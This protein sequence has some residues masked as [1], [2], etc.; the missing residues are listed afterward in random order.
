MRLLIFTLLLS[1]FST[2]N[3]FAQDNHCLDFNGVNNIAARAD[4]SISGEFTISAWF[5]CDVASNSS[6]DERII[7]FGPDTRL[8][9]GIDE[10][11]NELWLFDQSQN[12]TLSF[13]EDLRDQN[14]HQFAFVKLGT[15]RLV[16]IDGSLAGS[17]FATSNTTYGDDFRIGAWVGGSSSTTFFNGKVDDVRIWSVAKSADEI[18]EGL[19]CPLTG[20]EDDLLAY[21]NFD[22]GNPG[23]LNAL[24][25]ILLD[26]SGNARHCNLSSNFTLVGN[27]SNWVAAENDQLF[28]LDASINQNGNELVANASGLNYQW[29]DCDD[30]FSDIAGATTEVFAPEASGNYA[31]VVFNTTCTEASDCFD[32]IL[33]NTN[34]ALQNADIRVYPNPSVDFVIVEK[35]GLE[36]LDI[37]VKDQI[38]NTLLTKKTNEQKTEIDLRDFPTGVYYLAV[39]NTVRKIVKL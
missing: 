22:Q 13:G 30:N 27:S 36:A 10:F 37:V 1:T 33:S 17:Y 11:T 7:S 23:G 2:A 39:E 8:E 28:Y 16:Y 26:H 4:F 14:W 9:I 32:F 18:T 12:T 15:E 31:L 24:E 38:G 19:F 21:Y 35:E 6:F 34:E 5:R 29:V 20:N 25:T 3:I